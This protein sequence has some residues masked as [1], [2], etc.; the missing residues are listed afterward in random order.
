MGHTPS[1][2]PTRSFRW[3]NAERPLCVDAI[4]AD[5]RRPASALHSQPKAGRKA[6]PLLG[7]ARHPTDP[8]RIQAGQILSEAAFPATI[9]EK[10]GRGQ[11]SPAEIANRAMR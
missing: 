5:P 4:G 7:S 2:N 6:A 9:A 10:T 11:L 1:V 8:K 3:T